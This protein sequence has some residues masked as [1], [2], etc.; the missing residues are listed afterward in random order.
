M[1]DTP[2]SPADENDED[3]EYGPTL[4]NPSGSSWDRA[5]RGGAHAGPTIPSLQDLELKKG[6][7]R[8]VISGRKNMAYQ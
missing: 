1:S 7:S 8:V 2:K 5:G 3:D 4:P 6:K